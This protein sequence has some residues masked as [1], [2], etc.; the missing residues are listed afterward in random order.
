VA[1]TQAIG[2]TVD[3]HFARLRNRPSWLALFIFVTSIQTLA[4]LL[5]Y[6]ASIDQTLGSLPPSATG[7]DRVIVRKYLLDELPKFIGMVPIE[8]LIQY[9]MSALLLYVMCRA[10]RPIGTVRY[11]QFF[12]LQVRAGV[13]LMLQTLLGSIDGILNPSGQRRG[14]IAMLGAGGLFEI[15][16]NENVRLVAEACNVF[17]LLY[18][19]YVVFGVRIICGFRWLA[20]IGIGVSCWLISVFANIIP[21]HLLRHAFFD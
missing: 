12:S 5:G 4:A 2:S 10:F 16:A 9:G 18:V 15:A 7:A 19:V 1:V 20:S 3:R 11:S 17:S 13:V 6:S 21:L 8:I 14:L